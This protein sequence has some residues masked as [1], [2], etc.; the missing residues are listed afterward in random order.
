MPNPNSRNENANV[1]NL[2]LD[3]THHLADA[4]LEFSKKERT[5]QNHKDKLDKNPD[6]END[7]THSQSGDLIT[8][9]ILD[10]IRIQRFEVN[11][12]RQEKFLKI[13]KKII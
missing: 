4:E 9:V 5:N 13:S 8:P 12:S 11:H 2:P 7:Q 1:I 10:A 6:N 3:G